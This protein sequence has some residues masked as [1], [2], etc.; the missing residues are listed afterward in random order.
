[1][2]RGALV[3]AALALLLGSSAVDL[4]ASLRATAAAYR[5]NIAKIAPVAGRD[6]TY[7]YYERLIEDADL[8][9]DPSVPQGYSAAE[10][11]RTLARVAGLD[12]SLATQLLHE[13]YDSMS[14]IRGLGETVVRSSQDGT[15]QPVAVYV[16][17]SYSPAH[18]AP[19][20]VLLHG[21]PQSETQLLAPRYVADLAERSGAIV[22]APWGHG[23]Y[24]FRG[25]AADV[26]DALIAATYAFAID[27]RKRYL[28]GYSMGGFSV[29]EV[30]PV[31]PQDWSA[32][33]CIAGALLGSDS[34]RVVTLMRRTPFYV[35]TG[36]ADDS[37]PTQYPIATAAFLQ[38][39]GM[40]V[41]FY[42]QPGGIHRLVTLLPIL[43]LAWS[44]MLHAVVRAPPAQALGNITLPAM[45]PTSNF[46]P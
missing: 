9:D 7:D 3:T 13:S 31:H 38:S 20:I 42:S 2:T 6:T 12:L 21:R 16:P 28:A 34:Q 5:A 39:A 10:W 4:R 8:L 43:T 37:I 22:V 14:A 27:P 18:P 40:D 45:I 25:S 11:S 44:D 30:A 19:L 26:Y 17:T 29:F 1:M 35:L 23:Y 15:M 36:S 33:M 46:K 32:V 24:N 41:S